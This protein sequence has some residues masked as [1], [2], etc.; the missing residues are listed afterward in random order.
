MEKLSDKIR[1]RIV[2]DYINP[3]RDRGDREVTVVA[4]DIVRSMGLQNRTPAVCSALTSKIFL[5]AQ[6][7]ELIGREGPPS[8]NSTTMRYTYSLRGPSSK[9]SAF[10]ELRGAG[11]ELFASLGGGEHFIREERRRF[12]GIPVDDPEPVEGPD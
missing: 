11:K 10:Y 3:A 8:G 1:D 9:H 5:N 2:A 7:L 6:N 12:G 4:G